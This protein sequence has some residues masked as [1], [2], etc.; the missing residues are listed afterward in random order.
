MVA[1]GR[2]RLR[3]VVLRRV[4]GAQGANGE[5]AFTWPETPESKRYF[6]AEDA[7]GAGE[8]IV[9][10]IRQ[11]TGSK[12]LRIKGRSI[13]IAAV[14]RIKVV[15]GGELYDVTGVFRERADTVISV[16]RVQPQS[17]GQ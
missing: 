7:L 1:T 3:I 2:Y 9:Q 14:D 12:R 5:T 6:A 16:E 13:A 8:T 11:S 15:P 4:A 10:G 17:V